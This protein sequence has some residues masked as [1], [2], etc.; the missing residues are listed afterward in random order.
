MN[1]IQIGKGMGNTGLRV[2]ALA[3]GRDMQSLCYAGIIG[4][5]DPPRVGCA[6]AIEAV[7]AA[8][9]SVK[10]ITGDS[11]ET[12]CSIG[13]RLK[14]H[15]DSDSVLSGPQ[16]DNLSDADL[17][18]IISKVTIFCRATPKHKLRIV[19]VSVIYFSLTF[20]LSGPSKYRRSCCDDWRWSK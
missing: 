15:S 2:I 11:S 8:G 7:Q 18:R 5:F 1:V 10:M 17:E 6:E 4:I 14:I 19:K 3:R 13:L 20:I 12:A 9:V 16:I